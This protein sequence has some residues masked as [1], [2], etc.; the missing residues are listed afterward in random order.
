MMRRII[1]LGL[2]AA[3][4]LPAGC[5][6]TRPVLWSWPHHKRRVRTILEGFHQLHMDVDR[7]I[8]DMEERPIE[9]LD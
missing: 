8:F 5:M 4:L 9:D 3:F 7:I 6:T 2:L 1:A